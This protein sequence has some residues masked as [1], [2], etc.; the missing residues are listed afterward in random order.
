[1]RGIALHEAASGDY[2]EAGTTAN[3]AIHNNTLEGNSLFAVDAGTLSATVDASSNWW[4]TTDPAGV[5]AE[6]NGDVDYTPWLNSA[7]D[8]D[9]GSVGFQ[10]AYDV[11]WVDD[12][13]P[14]TGATGRIQ[15]AIGQVS[16]S[17]IYVVAGVYDS[18]TETFPLIIDKS[19]DLL[20]AQAN[21]DPRPTAGGRTGDETILDADETSAAVLQIASASNVEIN[22]FT[23]TG[24]TG[25][26][27]EEDGHAN[28]LLF[29]YNV[30]YDDLG[31]AGDEGIQIKD[32]DGV[33]V[34]YNYFYDILQ[35]AINISD[36][37]NS[38]VRYNEMHDIY[39]ENAA[40]YCYGATNTD[41]VE[42]LVYN[43]PNND[44]I[45]LGDSGDGSSGGPDKRQRRA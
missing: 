42:N 29:S 6:V 30:L 35:D 17:T 34:E 28:G 40:I 39:S 24:G 19:V 14:Q 20:G 5:R 16:G 1:M 9:L 43:V 25:D 8:Q 44:G 2:V 10:G 31:G 12:D 21:V 18:T 4:G 45:K 41:I 37:T 11:L 27:V 15:E 36:S 32:S 38:T 23:I 3:A 13:S 33:V 26:M 7:E 22:G